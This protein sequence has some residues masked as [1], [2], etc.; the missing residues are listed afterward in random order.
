M[1][2]E[3][4]IYNLLQE[5]G[6]VEV[7][8]FGVFTLEKKSAQYNEEQSTLLPPAQEI[9]FENQ[10]SV[11]NPE[12]SR[13]IVEKTSENLFEVQSKIKDEISSWK[14]ILQNDGKL[15]LEDLGEFVLTNDVIQFK[16]Q[17]DFTK[18]PNY[19]GLEAIPVEEISIKP[20]NNEEHQYVFNRSLLW[21]F[22]FIL[23]VGG[24]LF[25]A[26]SHQNEIFGKPST[27]TVKKAISKKEKS[28]PTITKD[29]LLVVKKDS[30]LKTKS[31]NHEKK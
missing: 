18:T 11:F 30:L 7:P 31:K 2:T 9:F 29:S 13:Y 8:G 4:H 15:V 17:K 22:L 3:I 16:A 5:I 14:E 21:S 23:P 24:M 12:L 19:F 27:L 26:F 28:L 6:R 10:P 20:T 25:L 1:N